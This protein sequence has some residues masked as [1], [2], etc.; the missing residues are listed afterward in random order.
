MI[1]AFWCAFADRLSNVHK[2]IPYITFLVASVDEKLYFAYAAPQ[3]VNSILTACR[4][5]LKLISRLVFSDISSNFIMQ[6][7]RAEGTVVMTQLC[8][9]LSC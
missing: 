3:T 5:V 6:T 9:V 7:E 8:N 2:R 4:S 1:V